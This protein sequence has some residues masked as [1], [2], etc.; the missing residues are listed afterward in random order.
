M[1]EEEADEAGKTNGD[2]DDDNR[3]IIKDVVNDFIL[4]NVDGNNAQNDSEENT[5][6]RKHRE[7]KKNYHCKIFCQV[8]LN[9]HFLE[10]S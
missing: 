9:M 7:N 5:P 4:L 10:L 1:I 8:N 2:N 3:H 6:R